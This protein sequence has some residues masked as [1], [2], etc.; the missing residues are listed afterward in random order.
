[1][2]ATV[3]KF[4]A[5]FQIISDIHLEQMDVCPDFAAKW[6]STAP[7]LILAGDI[8]HF[9][10]PHWHAFM[11]YVNDNWDVVIYVL[12]NHEF[13][14]NRYSYNYLLHCYNDIPLMWSNVILLNGNVA[15]ILCDGV[16]W[17]I[18][19]ATAWGAAEYSLVLS[20]N[21]FKKI[22]IYNADTDRTTPISVKQYQEMHNA[23]M[24][25]I[26]NTIANTDR[27]TCT[28]L[29]THFPLTR[30]GTSD[31]IY[32]NQSDALKRYFANELHGVLKDRPNLTVVSGHTHYK[33]DFIMDE[34]RYVSNFT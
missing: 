17:K 23:D 32:G 15:D 21:D 19:G 20:I 11:N 29:V 26:I 30:D 31:P 6:R 28:V 25:W 4:N 9:N 12:G 7:C 3:D 34:V 8:G 18:I 2:S 13:Y 16:I 5:A 27:S 1:M 24:D 22:K 33:Y 14:S 10:C